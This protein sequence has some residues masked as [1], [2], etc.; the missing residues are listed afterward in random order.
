MTVA[1]GFLR[2]GLNSHVLLAAC[3]AK[4]KAREEMGRGVFT[5]AFLEVLTN[6]GADKITYSDLLERMP[7]LPG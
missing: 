1:P 7:A 4:E 3:G 2:S 6:I 5:K